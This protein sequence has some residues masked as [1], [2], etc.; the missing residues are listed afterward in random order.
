[1]ALEDFCYYCG[2]ETRFKEGYMIWESFDGK[3]GHE[4][5]VE[6]YDEE[7]KSHRTKLEDE[8][9]YLEGKLRYF[10]SEKRSV[11]LK[12]DDLKIELNKLD[13]P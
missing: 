7:N 2:E 8:I 4:W 10:D 9:R 6:K 13:I 11:Q 3:Y 5:C 1:M 12:I